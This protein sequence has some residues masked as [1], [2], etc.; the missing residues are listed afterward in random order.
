VLLT[1]GSTAWVQLKPLHEKLV[2]DSRL[3]V[4]KTLAY[5]LFELAKIL[6]P[7]MTESELL[8]VLFHFMKD[9]DQV[10]EGVMV[11]LPDL[12]E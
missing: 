2:R 4:R 12:M 11:S 6:G 8:P 9:V 10:R 3:K 5:S 1:L 7:K